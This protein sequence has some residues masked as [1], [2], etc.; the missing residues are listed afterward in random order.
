MAASKLWNGQTSILQVVD[1]T[2]KTMV[3]RGVVSADSAPNAWDLRCEVREKLLAWLQREHP[4]ALP[5]LRAEL[6]PRS[7]GAVA[8]A[9]PDGTATE[10]P[11]EPAT[12][13]TPADGSRTARRSARP[14][15]SSAPGDST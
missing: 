9:A 13:E 1:A 3:L 4:E 6:P 15:K 7:A 10:S 11:A 5:R 8:D 2:E 14:R 12:Q